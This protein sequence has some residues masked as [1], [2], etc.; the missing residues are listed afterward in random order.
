MNSAADGK[1][2]LVKGGGVGPISIG[3]IHG[4]VRGYM[5]ISL[6]ISAAQKRA[7]TLR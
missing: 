7:S 4:Q 2:C 1:E 6:G 3:S 5:D